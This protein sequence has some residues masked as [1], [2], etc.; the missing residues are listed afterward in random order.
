MGYFTAA[1]VFNEPPNW[2]QL[3]GLCKRVK[4]TAF[5]HKSEPLWILA[6]NKPAK[7]AEERPFQCFL[8]GGRYPGP[9]LFDPQGA[10]KRSLVKAVAEAAPSQDGIAH[11]ALMLGAGIH[12]ALEIATYFFAADDEGLD[13]ALEFREGKLVRFKQAGEKG[14]VE[15]RD[16]LVSAEVN[17]E[18]D[19]AE[20][21]ENEGECRMFYGVPVSHWPQGWPDPQMTLG[22]GTWDPLLKLEED[23]EV[24]YRS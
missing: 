5:K 14:S 22:L 10:L 2:K 19:E 15:L 17:A 21:G 7:E 18:D 11:D 3:T 8:G 16:G 24:C 13:L 6:C 20:N 9:A 12:R 23:F 1:F 4:F